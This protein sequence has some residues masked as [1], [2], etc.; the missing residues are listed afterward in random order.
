MKRN[1]HDTMLLDRLY[2]MAVN[3]RAFKQVGNIAAAAQCYEAMVAVRPTDIQVVEEYAGCLAML[4]KKDLAA[5]VMEKAKEM[6]ADV[7]GKVQE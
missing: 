5:R 2:V 4:G 1:P 3:A 6:K 7:D